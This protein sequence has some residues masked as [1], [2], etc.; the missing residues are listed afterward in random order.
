M[1]VAELQVK[2]GADL[3]SAQSQ[4]ESLAQAAGRLDA[5]TSSAS[6]SMLQ[7]FQ[8]VQEQMKQMSTL[9]D[10][11]IM[12]QN[13][14][15]L[16]KSWNFVSETLQR[17]VSADALLG[18]D[19]AIQSCLTHFE[20]LGAQVASVQRLLANLSTTSLVG[21]SDQL[22]GPLIQLREVKDSLLA[23]VQAKIRAGE[24]APELWNAAKIE[25]YKERIQLVQSELV[26]LGKVLPFEQ[27]EA[28]F[29]RGMASITEYE[30]AL[31]RLTGLQAGNYDP[32]KSVGSLPGPMPYQPG[33]MPSS[34][35]GP[36]PQVMAHFAAGG[37]P[38]QGGAGYGLPANDAAWMANFGPNVAMGAY[39]PLPGSMGTAGAH[40]SI[41][42][43]STRYLTPYREDYGGA[44]SQMWQNHFNG[45]LANSTLYSPVQSRD[46]SALS[47]RMGTAGDAYL[48]DIRAKERDATVAS[49][50]EQEAAVLKV[51]EAQQ[52]V[53]G[54][55]EESHGAFGRLGSMLANTAIYSGFYHLLS[56]V[57]ALPGHLIA[58]AAAMEKLH[59]SFAA[60]FGKGAEEQFHFVSDTAQRFGKN[61]L[62]VS[63]PYQKFAASAE[64]VG[65]SDQNVKAIYESTMKAVSKTGGDEQSVA[66][67]MLA[68]E[69]MLSKGV[70]TSEE[71]RR[72]FAN[73]IPGAMKMGADALGVTT[74]QFKKMLQEGMIKTMDFLPKLSLE[75]NKFGEGWE[76]TTN[77]MISNWA[78]FTNELSKSSSKVLDSDLISSVLEGA[79]TVAAGMGD[80]V[81]IVTLLNSK[82]GKNLSSIGGFD[83]AKNSLN[84]KVGQI[85]IFDAMSATEKLGFYKDKESAYT[86]AGGHSEELSSL[87]D[88]MGKLESP[89]WIEQA[90]KWAND[91]NA[92]LAQDPSQDGHDGKKQYLDDLIKEIERIT[93]TPFYLNM[94]PI[95]NQD[96]VGEMMRGIQA[97]YDKTATGKLE[98]S[99]ELMRRQEKHMEEMKGR[100]PALQNALAGNDLDPIE[101]NN[102]TRELTGYNKT[103]RQQGIVKGEEDKKK[104][105]LID[106]AAGETDAGK[107]LHDMEEEHKGLGYNTVGAKDAHARAEALRNKERIR[108]AAERGAIDTDKWAALSTG[109]DKALEEKIAQNHKPHGANG[110]KLD[111]HAQ[112]KLE[113][114]AK[115]YENMWNSMWGDKNGK[116]GELELQYR[117]RIDALREQLKNFKGSASGRSAIEQ[118][119]TAEE[120]LLELAKTKDKYNDWFKG[121]KGLSSQLKIASEY[122]TPEDKDAYAQ[123]KVRLEWLKAAKEAKG[124]QLEIDLANLA[125][126]KE[127]NAI[128]EKRHARL[129][130]ENAELQKL[131]GNYSGSMSS[132]AA[133]LEAE[134]STADPIQR[135][136]LAER[137]NRLLARSNGDVSGMVGYGLQ[138]ARYKSGED[139][140][141][142]VEGAIPS[143]IDQAAQATSG[144]LVELSNHTKN[145]AQVWKDLAQTIKDSITRI[146]ADLAMAWAKKELFGLFGLGDGNAAKSPRSPISAKV[147]EG[148]GH[149][150]QNGVQ[151]MGSAFAQ[152][153]LLGLAGSRG[154]SDLLGRISSS[155]PSGVWFGGSSGNSY[156]SISNG[157]SFVNNYSGGFG[158][159]SDSSSSIGGSNFM[160]GQSNAGSEY[161]IRQ[162]MIANPGASP[163]QAA[164]AVGA[165]GAA[166]GAKASSGTDYTG[167][168]T[169]ALDYGNK[170]QGL[171]NGA[172]GI[173]VSTPAQGW[174]DALAFQANMGDTSALAPGVLNADG[175][176]YYNMAT[177]PAGSSGFGAALGSGVGAAGI[178]YMAGGLMSTQSPA[179]SYVG[180]GAG[181]I[182]GMAASA[183]GLGSTIAGSSM[184]MGLSA[185]LA[186]TGVGALVGVAAA[187][188]M[189]A[190][191]PDKVTT[192]ANGMKGNTITM[193][194]GSALSGSQP[195][196]GFQGF[197]ET[198]EG[199]FGKSGTKHFTAPTMADPALA[200][201][202][203][204]EFGQQVGGL[205]SSLYGLNMG[206]RALSNYS[207]PVSFDV[208]KDNLSQ[209]TINI[210]NDMARA[211]IQASNLEAAFTA[212]LKPGEDF[213]DAIKRIGS[214]Y[215][216]TNIE[217]QKAGTSLAK[218]S[219][220]SNVVGQGDWASRAGSIM[221]GD[222]NLAA[223]FSLYAQYGRSQAAV[224]DSGL[225]AYGNQAAAAIGGL[226]KP[227]LNLSNFWGEYG[228]ALQGGMD[229]PQLQAWGNAAN[230][231]KLFDDQQ[232]VVGQSMIAINSQRIAQLQA[233]MKAAQQTKVMVDGLNVSVSSAYSSFNGLNNTLISSI[234]GIR[235]NSSLSPLTPQQSYQEQSDYYN[236]L[237]STVKGEG[238][239][240]ITY[241]ADVQKLVSFSS[242]FL[243][244]AKSF[245][246]ASQQ[247]WDVYNDVSTT[248][249]DL[250]SQ[251]QTEVDVLK[252]QL[253]GQDVLISKNQT[254]IDELGMVNTN[255]GLLMSSVDELG[256]DILRG[257]Q[258]GGSSASS[259]P[260]SA[261]IDLYN[262]VA[263]VMGMESY[264]A[265]NSPAPSSA[266]SSPAP[267][268]D[269][270][271]ANIDSASDQ[272]MGQANFN[273]VLALGGGATGGKF[274]PSTGMAQ[275]QVSENGQ[276]FITLGSGASAHVT[277]NGEF[278]GKMDE[279]TQV[280]AG[281]FQALYQQ[282]VKTNQILS[283]IVQNSG[284]ADAAPARMK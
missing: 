211:A 162:Y 225:S 109:I 37:P 126:Q 177:A 116:A 253:Q 262:S 163:Q 172:N 269:W 155:T 165:S 7:N 212:A 189:A 274:G 137:R 260:S 142:K 226:G 100:M 180:A 19:S 119:I 240:S 124:Q 34:P 246:G 277:N 271:T 194:P 169:K 174:S 51:A 8:K 207:F 118:N 89:A 183:S 220:S 175:A 153:G 203:D 46:G 256:K 132:Q 242:S 68:F 63:K 249:S 254:Q 244:T 123:E 272:A 258:S 14:D 248:L 214:A 16:G 245:L 250:Q 96:A 95:L 236:K 84:E 259:A 263:Q 66:S 133:S 281:G 17:R 159:I 25:G 204:S 52:K 26:T 184:A 130:K 135:Q 49:I 216:A 170:I 3:G 73:H 192:A 120:N 178:G 111:M 251:T 38:F 219:G 32:F 97:I 276:E 15:K 234:Q 2:V 108:I 122:G 24:V 144:H 221:G 22:N 210:A 11:D 9:N 186:A 147:G 121:T 74:E 141:N 268:W 90:S 265:A 105:G 266:S 67:T 58:S 20:D 267:A 282:S 45:N 151:D 228:Q 171:F 166:V 149:I 107:A 283:S 146:L 239:N 241:S 161:L 173:S 71:F 40:D 115:E 278:S 10:V 85:R 114:T 190:A 213:L 83:P 72:Q 50:K 48:S 201:Q 39:G 113:Q 12:C 284:L 181:L 106:A 156:S 176:S 227:G 205:T 148:Y 202:W 233:E 139:Y 209:A 145:F 128:E 231:M 43:T 257:L 79:T 99:E 98:T 197:T 223:G 222:A 92:S 243:T 279:N 252:Q 195:T 23:V 91:L 206:T 185:G 261:S 125:A 280:T 47:N 77:T 65:M 64:Y 87:K 196:W 187:A 164:A 150:G 33:P 30:A 264:G 104:W 138:D 182:G 112:D 81:D 60:V 31:R 59:A 168:A 275:F 127:M 193:A 29:R 5:A 56:A 238:P 42:F 198:T 217:A 75:M 235:W 69:Q 208:N 18:V 224:A 4:F 102:M 273:A 152:Y 237:K 54:S 200:K 188:I 6:K 41:P 13:M 101:R 103:L 232:R 28:F 78:R 157:S 160:G 129:M 35:Y 117:K 1:D 230:W 86:M 247:Y 57:M 143:I 134:M 270:N 27:F 229:G 55:T 61:I 179:A 140:S 44:N 131:R 62:D 88:L 21:L 110:P 199:S 158:A 53:K 167:Y 70:V 218:L 36:G 94:V 93:K 154:A 136:V 255:L 76:K 80:A 191:T 215:N 82:T